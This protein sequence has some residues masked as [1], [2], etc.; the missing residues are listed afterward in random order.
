MIT[1]SAT[2]GE[3]KFA[4][5][6]DVILVSFFVGGKWGVDRQFFEGA[7]IGEL[8]EAEFGLDGTPS[9]MKVSTKG[10]DGWRLASLSIGDCALM[11]KSRKYYLKGDLEL[12]FDLGRTW[13]ARCALGCEAP[14]AD[15]NDGN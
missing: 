5:T 2:T 10:N 15:D 11:P 1:V 9:K 14:A 7:V 8:K 3:D 6:K 12:E 13:P 4:A